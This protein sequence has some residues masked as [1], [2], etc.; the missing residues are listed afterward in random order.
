MKILKTLGIIGIKYPMREWLQ[1]YGDTL[2][3]VERVIESCE[4]LEQI[5]SAWKFADLF[6]NHCKRLNVN[7]QTRMVMRANV[8]NLLEDRWESL[9]LKKLNQNQ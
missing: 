3:K 1:H 2:K 7:E 4:T 5:G 9:R 8:N 6:E